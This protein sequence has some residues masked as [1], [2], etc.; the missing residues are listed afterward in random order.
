M[1]Q[2]PIK[3]TILSKPT[4]KQVVAAWKK[5][6]CDKILN[7]KDYSILYFALFDEYPNV[8]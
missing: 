8:K 5:F 3:Q 4:K 6:N 7:D 2:K 1:K